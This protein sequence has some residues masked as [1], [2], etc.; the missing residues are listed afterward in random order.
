MN[1]IN[2][3]VG[4][5]YHI[6]YHVHQKQNRVRQMRILVDLVKAVRASLVVKD[7][8]NRLYFCS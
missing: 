6:E 5:Y 7:R 3:K 8:T 2:A 1:D 4:L